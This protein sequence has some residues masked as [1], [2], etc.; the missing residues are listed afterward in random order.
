MEEARS[1]AADIRAGVVAHRAALLCKG[2]AHGG[3]EMW[4]VSLRGAS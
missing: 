4:L 1:V 3:K 2:V